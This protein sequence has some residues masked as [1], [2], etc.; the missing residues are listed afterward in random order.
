MITEENTIGIG[1]DKK[2]MNEFLRGKRNSISIDLHDDNASNFVE[3]MEGDYS[4]YILNVEEVPIKYHG[5]YF[6]NNGV[7]PYIIKKELENI[8]LVEGD[9][10]IVGRIVSCTPKAGQR[11][12]F[13]ENPGD[14]S[15]DDP[16]GD[17]CIW[18]LTFKLTPA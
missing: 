11:F 3:Y 2:T 12:R 5:C 7:F 15:I 16:N 1:I 17:S 10:R 14:P 8:M 13:G 9:T 4:G 6:Y 18:N